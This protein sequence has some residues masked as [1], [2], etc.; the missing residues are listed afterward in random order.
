MFPS[1]LRDLLSPSCVAILLSFLFHAEGIAVEKSP[2]SE[3]F[4]APTR[5]VWKSA[6]GVEH[7]DNLLKPKPGQA[8]LKE[9]TP[10]CVLKTNGASAP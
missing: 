9:P 2:L 1:C 3:S 8:V 5:V 4:I 10:P 6:T 7:A